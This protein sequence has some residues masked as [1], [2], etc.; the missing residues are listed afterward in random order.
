MPHGFIQ[1]KHRDWGV[2]TKTVR[3]L[4]DRKNPKAR[5]FEQRR[6]KRIQAIQELRLLKCI[7]RDGH[8]F[9]TKARYSIDGLPI[10]V[11][12]ENNFIETCT[13]CG[14][15]KIGGSTSIL[16]F[17]AGVRSLAAFHKMVIGSTSLHSFSSG[18]SCKTKKKL[19]PEEKVNKWKLKT[20]GFKK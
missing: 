9:K 4:R 1:C 17:H 2:M 10:Y 3:S 19:S 8:F 11:S 6:K 12:G 20:M 14:L 5:Y 15:K 18:S 16:E 7:M 13:A